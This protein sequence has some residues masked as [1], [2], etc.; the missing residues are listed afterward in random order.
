MA[1]VIWGALACLPFGFSF[2]ALR[3]ST[4]LLA[5][6]ALLRFVSPVG[7]AEL[8]RFP[9]ERWLGSSGH[10][11][12]LK[13]VSPNVGNATFAESP[14]KRP[15]RSLAETGPTRIAHVGGVSASRM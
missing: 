11:Y 9:Y 13:S 8:Q 3:V 12:A 10:I 1:Q 4:W 6:A 5:L 2:T 14:S 15:Q 7:W